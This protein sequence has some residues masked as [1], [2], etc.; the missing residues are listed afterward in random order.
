MNNSNCAYSKLDFACHLSLL[1]IVSCNLYNNP[2]SGWHPFAY[3]LP[4]LVVSRSGFLPFT[5]TV[6]K[7]GETTLALSIGFVT[8]DRTFF[9]CHAAFGTRILRHRGRTYPTL[10]GRSTVVLAQPAAST[11]AY[12]PPSSSSSDSSSSSSGCKSSARRWIRHYST[13]PNRENKRVRPTST[14]TQ[15]ARFHAARNNRP[16]QHPQPSVGRH[17][18]KSHIKKSPHLSPPSQN[19]RKQT[20]PPPPHTHPYVHRAPASP[21]TC[22]INSGVTLNTRPTHPNQNIFCV[23]SAISYFECPRS[24]T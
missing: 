3:L 4:I 22:T 10:G 2:V 24:C 12:H 11:L 19:H 17:R 18:L 13:H 8:T 21:S 9:G 5:V 1:S 16:T 14:Q 23:F 7:Y 20:L 15:F 6:L